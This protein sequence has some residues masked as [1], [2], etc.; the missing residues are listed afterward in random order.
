MITQKRDETL[1]LRKIAKVVGFNILLVSLALLAFKSTLA[2][3]LAIILMPIFC[4]FYLSGKL[5]VDL[6]IIDYLSTL[7]FTISFLPG[8]GIIVIIGLIKSA[9]KNRK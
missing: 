5:F 1:D 9:V 6:M 2:T 3:I 4:H 8:V 7:T